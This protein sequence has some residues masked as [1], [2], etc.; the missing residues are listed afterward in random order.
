MGISVI[1]G[2]A[3][4]FREDP[5]VQSAAGESPRNDQSSEST[6]CWDKPSMSSLMILLGVLLIVLVIDLL[7]INSSSYG[8]GSQSSGEKSSLAESMLT[9]IPAKRRLMDLFPGIEAIN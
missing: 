8:S 7:V 4:L 5:Q 2:R 6:S 3:M 9:G 1:G